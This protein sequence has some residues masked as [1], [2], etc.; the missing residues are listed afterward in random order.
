MP[1][2]PAELARYR[3]RR[4]VTRPRP[5][6][7]RLASAWLIRRFVDPAAAIRYVLQ[8]KRIH[9]LNIGMRLKEE[10]DANIKILCGETAYTLEDRALLAG[11]SA[12][13]Y[14]TDAIKKMRIE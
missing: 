6:V 14:E 12:R 1:V 8:D 11:Y 13:L 10:I 4:W 7:D 3:G 2:A 9:L 5:H